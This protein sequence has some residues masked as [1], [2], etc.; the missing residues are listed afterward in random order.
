LVKLSVI[1]VNYRG[2]GPLSRCLEALNCLKDADFSSEVIIVDNF[3]NDGKLKEFSEQRSSFRFIENTGN[4]GFSS[5]NN[6]GARSSNGEYMLF[7][8]PDT[9]I[10]LPALSEL[11]KKAEGHPEYHILSC[12]QEDENGKDKNPFGSFPSF[13]TLTGFNRAI[14]SLFGTRN[15]ENYQC[16]GRGVIFPDWVSGSLI[17]MKKKIFEQ[18][19]GWCE[20][21]WLYSEDVDL[22]KRVSEQGGKVA[23]LCDIRIMHQHGGV[24][25]QNN[26]L[27][28]YTKAQVLISSHIYISKHYEG[29]KKVLLQIYLIITNLLELLLPAVLGLIL[30]LIPA[31]H[32]YF[33]LFEHLLK[34]YI[35]SIFR[36]TWLPGPHTIDFP[37]K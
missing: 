30:F 13:R 31:V 10:N 24:T 27:K 2:W 11:I 21:F 37:L 34:Y 6:L 8:N 28:S 35:K 23:F 32:V 22:C 16:D 20:D 29:L 15:K 33:N 25:R 12:Q 5:G 19:G 14:F 18:T 7:L 3:S 36:R 4:Y 26:K 17:F 9:V 1:I